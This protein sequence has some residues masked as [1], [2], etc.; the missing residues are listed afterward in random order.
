MVVEELDKYDFLTLVSMEESNDESNKD[1]KVDGTNPDYDNCKYEENLTLI[2]G[3]GFAN[4]DN[5]L[6]DTKVR[7]E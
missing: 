6:T 7:F 2:A 5:T 4:K 1:Q 3:I